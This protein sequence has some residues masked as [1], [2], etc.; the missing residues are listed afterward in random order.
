[1]AREMSGG[2]WRAAEA[3]TSELQNSAVSARVMVAEELHSRLTSVEI[4]ILLLL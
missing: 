1:M 4:F 3:G 2:V